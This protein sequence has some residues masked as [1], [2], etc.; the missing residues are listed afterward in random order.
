MS[1]AAVHC[2]YFQFNVVKAKLYHMIKIIPQ[3]SSMIS[4]NKLQISKMYITINKNWWQFGN[5]PQMSIGAFV[6]PHRTATVLTTDM[7]R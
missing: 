2:N 3:F 5:F 1:T 7:A 4:N 6:V